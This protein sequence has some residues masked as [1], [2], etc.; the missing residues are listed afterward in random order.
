VQAKYP[1]FGRLVRVSPSEVYIVALEDKE[2]AL[3]LIQRQVANGTNVESIGRAS[4]QL[5][6]APELAPGQFKKA[7]REER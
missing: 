6:K 5:L 3:K 1:K 2:S 7:D 4:L